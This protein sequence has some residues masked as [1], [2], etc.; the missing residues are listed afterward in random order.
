MGNEVQSN[1][2]AKPNYS[3]G[4]DTLVIWDVIFHVFLCEPEKP[5]LDRFGFVQPVSSLVNVCS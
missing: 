1:Q 4:R 5:A 3:D 2:D